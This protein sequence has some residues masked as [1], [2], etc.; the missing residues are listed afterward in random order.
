MDSRSSSLSV[1]R[2]TSGCTG[3]M[4]GLELSNGS[5][6]PGKRCA[7]SSPSRSSRGR[8]TRSRGR[9][10]VV[11]DV[12]L[13]ATAG[14][15]CMLVLGAASGGGPSVRGLFGLDGLGG[16]GDWDAVASREGS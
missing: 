16:T 4:C 1:S 12:G 5:G 11:G 6:A 15:L 13:F 9:G 10:L 2:F 8:L 7:G 3:G 14:A